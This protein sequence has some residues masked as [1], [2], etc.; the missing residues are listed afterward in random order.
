M[1]QALKPQCRKELTKA[2][3]A[4]AAEAFSTPANLGGLAKWDNG[5]A[6]PKKTKPAASAAQNSNP[7]H[8]INENSGRSSGF[9]SLIC[10]QGLKPRANTATRKIPSSQM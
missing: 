9:P 5:S 4:E 1:H 3:W 10:P 6:T 2:H 8:S 7:N